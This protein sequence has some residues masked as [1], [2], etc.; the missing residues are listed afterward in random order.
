M[1]K[2][3]I[4]ILVS[5][6]CLLVTNSSFAQLFEDFEGTTF[7]PSG[8]V[9]FDNGIGTVESWKRNTITSLNY[10]ASAGA[11]YVVRE[12]V[13]DGSFAEDWLVTPQIAV[14][15]NKELS[16]YTRKAVGT[17][18]GT[19]Y[20]IRISTTSQSN[21]A[22]F[23]TIQS[24]DD[25]TIN[26]NQSNLS[27]EQKKIDL[28]AYSGQNI[29]IAFVMTNDNGNRWLVDN[30]SIREKCLTPTSIQFSNR[31]PYG[32]DIS[33][34]ENNPSVTEWEIEVVP[35]SSNPTGSG[36][37]ISSNPYS[38]TGLTP[39]T[40]YKVYVRSKCSTN[41]FSDWDY[42]SFYTL[43][44]CPKPS[45][46]LI[47]D[48]DGVSATI[49]WTETG[50]ATSWEVVI[51]P[52]SIGTPQT[53][54]I[55]VNN[56]TEYQ[57]SNLD[58][59]EVY[60]A[61]I[62]SKCNGEDSDW[63]SII[64][65]NQGQGT[66]CFK[67]S[68][69]HAT[70]AKIR[71]MNLLNVIRDNINNSFPMLDGYQCPELIDLSPFITDPY[72]ALYNFSNSNGVIKFSFHET[73]NADEFDVK[74]VNWLNTSNQP[75]SSLDTDAFQYNYFGPNVNNFLFNAI[76]LTDDT[77]IENLQLK[78]IDFCNEEVFCTATNPNSQVVK[79][80]FSNLVSHISSI[81]V[82][83]GTVDSTYN[84]IHL[85]NL[86]P[87]ITVPNPGIYNFNVNYNP[88]G[89]IF[90][91][92]FTFSNTVTSPG[93][94]VNIEFGNSG[95]TT[96]TDFDSSTY[97]SPNVMLDRVPSFNNTDSCA[98]IYLRYIDLCPSGFI[99]CT[100]SNPNTPHI[101]KLLLNLLSHL[102]QRKLNGDSDASIEGSIPP[103]LTVLAPYISDP[104]PVS[105]NNFISTY[106]SYNQLTGFSFSFSPDHGPDINISGGNFYNIN[107]SNF[108]FD[109]SN[110]ND[111][112]DGINIVDY[113]Y[114]NFL[115][116]NGSIKHIEFCP[117]ELFCK[118]HVAIVVD[119]SGS[120]DNFEK[121]YIKKQLKSFIDKQYQDNLT[122][123][124]NMYVYLIGLS[125]N[126][127]DN[128][129]DNIILNQEVNGSNISQFHQWINGYRTGRVTPNADYWNSGLDVALNIQDIELVILITDGSQ[130]NDPANLQNTIRKFNNNGGGNGNPNAPHLYVIGIDN[131]FYVDNP[132]TDASAYN[133]LS[134][135]ENPN[136][137]PE[138]SRSYS[139]GRVTSYL[140]KSLKYLMEFSDIPF[141]QFP[142]S[143]QYNFISRPND[144]SGSNYENVDYFGTDSFRFLYENLNYLS[145]GLVD[146]EVALSC[147]DFIPL[148]ACNDC[149]NF[150][151]EV[152]KEYILSAW[153]KE[154]QNLQVKTYE[155]PEI[156]V[157][158]KDINE[159]FIINS[160]QICTTKGDII[161]GWQRI[162]K[163][164]SVPTNAAY[165]NIELVNKSTNTPVYFDDIRIHPK[166]GS[167]KSFVYDPETFRLMSELDEN[168]YSTFYE[169]DKEG[170]LIRVKK[171]TSRGVKT[172]QE[173]RSGNV[174][175]SED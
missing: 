48:Y 167:M 47:Q 112:E 59:E 135:K 7:P 133:R 76:K 162:F 93:Y 25:A 151:L 74:I 97:Y 142:I 130:T 92:E 119:E 12:N 17:N 53:P 99:S 89:S 71:F 122:L 160:L 20:S 126:D 66:N 67:T 153:V 1:G 26:S 65:N 21:A 109:L 75:I 4:N 125:D 127:I 63:S 141:P 120:I 2:I 79:Q 38:L 28:S 6:I 18:Y 107:S 19:N 138:L 64:I 68:P 173:T 70:I 121:E 42:I 155:N 60:I 104:D 168:N 9:E 161:D 103:Q 85:Q 169:Y 58:D 150:Q 86:T 72:P 111:A 96:L 139:T 55:I 35:Y 95:C 90:N 145:N 166:D 54:G 171:E 110:Y 11:A 40:Y 57:V 50:S 154:E 172:I 128:R 24:W 108:Q 44:T 147:G 5:F 46:N 115:I 81:I 62:R 8:W 73:Q 174:I 32:A 10:N 30:V 41:N 146:E 165:I 22:S 118:H 100:A 170:G 129:A 175:K 37:L 114:G 113:N 143:D 49:N 3:K 124:T 52:A 136:L 82:S 98:K 144:A 27:Y 101:Q 39:N 132:D 116:K 131:G 80:L 94:D 61:Y 78:H 31:T 134:N 83:G 148:E 87:Y 105:I 164:F 23:T 77:I 88:D 152:G 158:F 33:W 159:D 36:N 137:N 14:S 15:T 13:A 34:V 149:V 157:S 51:Q 29:Y 117:D 102:I 156:H 84:S 91:F 16:F 163:S 123:G 56:V 106:N 140:R 43:E 69:D 45:I